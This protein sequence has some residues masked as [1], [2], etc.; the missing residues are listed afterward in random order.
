MTLKCIFE[1]EVCLKNLVLQQYPIEQKYSVNLPHIF[2]FVQCSCCPLFLSLLDPPRHILLFFPESDRSR[3][4][5]THFVVTFINIRKY[6]E[7]TWE[8]LNDS[9]VFWSLL[10]CCSMFWIGLKDSEVI[11]SVIK[12]LKCL[13]SYFKC[14]EVFWSVLKCFEVFQRVLK[15]S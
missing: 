5:Q 4:C 1:L 11:Q 9:S 12:C 8:V 14:S 13:R 10:K 15:W 2:P 7:L 3:N 6:E